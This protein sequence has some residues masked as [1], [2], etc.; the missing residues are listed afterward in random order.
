MSVHCIYF[1]PPPTPT[2]THV[3]ETGEK[4][5]KTVTQNERFGTSMFIDSI[6]VF[7]QN[8][9][10]LRFGFSVGSLYYFRSPPLLKR[11]HKMSDSA[12]VRL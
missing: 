8:T 6:R 4:I 12:Q 5:A 9:S 2:Q 1:W 7:T 3:S 10:F 11:G